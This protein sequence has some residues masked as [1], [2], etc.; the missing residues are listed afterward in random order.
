[1]LIILY[2]LAYSNNSNYFPVFIA[3]YLYSTGIEI[4]VITIF[5]HFRVI[6][7][8]NVFLKK[9]GEITKSSTI[10]SKRRHLTI[11]LLTYGITSNTEKTYIERVLVI[12]LSF[13][14]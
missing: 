8:Q 9:L 5:N 7:L 3:F 13:L 12:V 10:K 2:R 4:D 11:D 1:M 14:W 6:V